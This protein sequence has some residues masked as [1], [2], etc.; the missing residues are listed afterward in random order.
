MHRIPIDSYYLL[1]GY[2]RAKQILGDPLAT[3]PK[4]PIIPVSK[5]TWWDGVKSGRFPK[6]IK[7]SPGITVWKVDDIRKLIEKGF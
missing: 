4:P 6:P 1:D 5:S 2:L 7:L 3:P